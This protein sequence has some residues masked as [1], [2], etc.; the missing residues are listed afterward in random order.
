MRAAGTG[1]ALLLALALQ[2]LGPELATAQA[3]RAAPGVSARRAEEFAVFLA[4][5]DALRSTVNQGV[6]HGWIARI[7]G[8]E[9]DTRL[10]RLRDDAQAL[11]RAGGPAPLEQQ[12][13]WATLEG[14][15]ERLNKTGQEHSGLQ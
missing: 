10:T 1:F 6:A 7:E 5:V 4:S 13:L 3:A 14:L 2:P 11:K 15:R 8:H 12:A 9:L